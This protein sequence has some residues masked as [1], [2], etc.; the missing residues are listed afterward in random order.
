MWIPR[1]IWTMTGLPAFEAVAFL[2]VISLNNTSTVSKEIQCS[3]TYVAGSLIW[4]T[5]RKTTKTCNDLAHD[6]GMRPFL[7]MVAPCLTFNRTRNVLRSYWAAQT[8]LVQVRRS[9]V[10]QNPPVL[11]ERMTKW[12][13]NCERDHQ[14]SITRFCM[15]PTNIWSTVTAE[16][17]IMP[18]IRNTQTARGK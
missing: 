11:C 17:S 4:Y 5:V 3:Y 2:H 16:W 10:L 6:A 12:R 8:T 14:P 13:L 15:R 9:M 1:S 7:K 18:F